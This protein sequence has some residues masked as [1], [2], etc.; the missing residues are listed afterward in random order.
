M[1]SNIGKKDIEKN[2]K[3]FIEERIDHIDEKKVEIA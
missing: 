2:I 1:W 3:E